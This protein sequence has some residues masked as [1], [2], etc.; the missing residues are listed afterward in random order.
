VNHNLSWSTTLTLTLDSTNILVR[1][2]AG[3]VQDVDDNSYHRVTIIYV[4]LA[5]SSLVI[6]L[7]L[8]IWSWFAVDLQ[9]LQYNRKRRIARGA[10]ILERKKR[11]SEETKGRN[12]TT[13]IYCLSTLLLYV[14]GSWAAYFWGVATGNN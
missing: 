2:I 12:R 5:M 13:G 8:L 11:A 1:I 14:L 10:F 3:V 9:L 4:F 6:S 7:A